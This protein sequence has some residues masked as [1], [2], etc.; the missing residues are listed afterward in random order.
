MTGEFN[1]AN[2]IKMISA[3]ELGQLGDGEVA[4]I[5]MLE[6]GEA[7]G[8]FPGLSGIPDGINLYALTGADGTPLA[9]TDSHS[10]AMEHAMQGELD[11]ASVH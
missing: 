11:I 6:P 7:G 8:L 5:K 1:E 4:Y 10:A 3:F 2:N 9:L